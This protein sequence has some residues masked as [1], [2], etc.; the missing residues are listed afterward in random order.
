MRILK[1]IL[2]LT[3]SIFLVSCEDV[4][5]VDLDTAEPRLV[6]DASIDWVK[7]TPG[8][9]QKII[10][11]TTTG[12]YNEEFPSVSGADIAI[13]NTAGTI[14][15]FIETSGTGEYICTNFEPAIGETYTLTVQLNN[16]AYTAT[17]TLIAVPEIENTI[18]QENE[19]GFGGD[20]VEVTFYY[21]D[22]GNQVNYYLFKFSDDNVAFP[23]YSVEDDENNQGNLTP[24][25]YS[26]EDLEPGDLINFKLYG[27][28]ERF[29]DYFKKILIASGNDDGPFQSTPTPVRGNILNQ[30]NSKNYTFGY[31]RLSEVDTKDYTIQ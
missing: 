8:N 26:N 17:E 1:K 4:I 11:S 21:Q 10:L 31:F 20:E 24:V 3:I 14:F 29:Y 5:E 2:I 9:E 12:Y 25:Y 13:T 22:N 28:S 30:T 6:I 7:G 18:E 19:G 23:Q 27:I 16:E 15:N